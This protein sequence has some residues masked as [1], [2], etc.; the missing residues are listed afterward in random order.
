MTVGYAHLLARALA[1]RWPY[2]PEY[3]ASDVT[4]PA[5]QRYRFMTP[6]RGE[7]LLDSDN[8]LLAVNV[9]SSLAEEQTWG[10][11]VHHLEVVVEDKQVGIEFVADRYIPEH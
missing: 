5:L 1:G 6:L 4:H 8:A 9:L 10:L 2:R 3:M 7:T 11:K